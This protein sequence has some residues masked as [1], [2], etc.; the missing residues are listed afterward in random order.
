MR[1]VGAPQP[2]ALPLA[3]ARE[4]MRAALITKGDPIALH[5]VENVSLPT[6]HGELAMRLYRPSEGV[7]PLGLF[8]HGGGWILND[9]DTH[10]RLCRRIA[11]RSG[12]LLGALDY[13]RAPE[14]KHPAPLEDAQLAYRWLL[15]NAEEIEGDQAAIALVGES[16]GATTAA[17]LSVLLRD[18]GAPM[19]LFQ[20]LAYPFVDL[21]GQ[22]PSREERGAGY[23]LDME[24]VRWAIRAYIPVGHDP[25][26]PYLFPL[27][28]SDFRRI[29]PTLVMTAEFDPL[30]DEGRAYVEKLRAAGVEV[31]HIH[32]EDQMH[33]FMLVD[34]AVAKAGALIDRLADA[35]SD[36]RSSGAAQ[37]FGAAQASAATASGALR[38]SP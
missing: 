21:L 11:R 14:H 20:I 32:A 26:D 1:A 30:R 23:I 6:P 35:L 31:E 3:E 34:R 37:V 15:D 29:P 17:C 25:R 38:A 36:R 27:A 5:S 22:W 33:G 19:P 8:L 9:L 4:S 2:Y 16:S 13:R 28:A 7:L 12:W 24:F 18:L 10:D